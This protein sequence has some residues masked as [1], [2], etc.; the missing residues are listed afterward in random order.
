MFEAFPAAD[1]DMLPSSGINATEK[2]PTEDYG[3]LEY[4]VPAFLALCNFT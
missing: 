4:T 1:S 3:N 2:I